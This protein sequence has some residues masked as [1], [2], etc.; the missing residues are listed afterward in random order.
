MCCGIK[1]AYSAARSCP[2]GAAFSHHRGQSVRRAGFSLKPFVKKIIRISAKIVLVGIVL[3]AAVPVGLV[4]IGVVFIAAFT[5]GLVHQLAEHRVFQRQLSGGQKQ[6]T[7]LAG[8][9][10]DDVDVMLFDEPL[11]NLDPATGK[12]GIKRRQM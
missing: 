2:G 9:M 12:T 10:I 11:A 3:I 5:V 6:R 1:A 8:V 4:L 7:A